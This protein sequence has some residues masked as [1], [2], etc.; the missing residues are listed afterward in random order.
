VP[1]VTGTIFTADVCNDWKAKF[2][3]E[4]ITGS[5]FGP[6][7]QATVTFECGENPGAY[8]LAYGGP[9]GIEAAELKAQQ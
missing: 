2:T 4:M 8:V 3:R 6:G 7:V 1:I 9:G 5:D